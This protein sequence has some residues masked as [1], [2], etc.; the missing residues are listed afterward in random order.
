MHR[1]WATGVVVALV[2]TLGLIF[3]QIIHAQPVTE[4]FKCRSATGQVTY[5]NDRRQAERQKCELVTSQINVA[6]PL[7]KPPARKSSGFPRETARDSATA[8]ERQRE[9][10][11][12]ELA[13]EEQALSKARQAL[14][15][16][17]AVRSGDERNYARVL[18]RLQ[19]YKDSVETH[20]KNIE[21]LKRELTNLNR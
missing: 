19:P 7:T 20:Q 1:A 2:G 14:A 5:T 11:Q 16:Q 15:E 8:R 3:P 13:S 21:A 18:E 6:P 12:Q 4:I 10:L 17:E 9:I